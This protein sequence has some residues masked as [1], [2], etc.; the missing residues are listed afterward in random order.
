VLGVDAMLRRLAAARHRLTLPLARAARAFHDARGWV[1][2]G[3]SQLGDWSREH[4]DRSGRWLRQLAALDRAVEA[5]PQLGLALSGNDGGPPL[6]VCAVLEIAR[7]CHRPP[8]GAPEAADH[9]AAWIARARTITLAELR[10]LTRS[11]I[12]TS[13]DSRATDTH[14][15]ADL[16]ADAS[17]H[18][19]QLAVPPDVQAAFEETLDLHRAVAG[20]ETGIAGFVEALC[21][22]AST[23]ASSIST[24]ASSPRDVPVTSVRPATRRPPRDTAWEDEASASLGTTALR[25][26]DATLRRLAA[27][28][29]AL[30]S[31]SVDVGPANARAVG[32]ALADLVACQDRIEVHIG[33]LLSDLDAARPW[34]HSPWSSA[35]DP[36]AQYA[37]DRLRMSR[38]TA[39]DRVHAARCLQRLPV[40]RAAYES[41][42]L[43][44]EKTLLLLR[45]SALQPMDTPLQ[46]RWM[47][48]ATQTTLKRLR[49]EYRA[50]RQQHALRVSDPGR[51]PRDTGL[52]PLDDAAWLAS[53]GRPAGRTRSLVLETGCRI[54]ARTQAARWSPVVFLQVRLPE[55]QANDFAA[56]IDSARRALCQEAARLNA[57]DSA[58]AGDGA[59]NLAAGDLGAA[60]HHGTAAHLGAAA[61]ARLR[62]SLRIA[63]LCCQQPTGVP[64]W[65]GLL[66]LLEEYA[67]TWDAP[68]AMHR[69]R[70]DRIHARA[71]WRCTCAGC[72]RRSGLEA[73]HV[74]YRSHGGGNEPENVLSVCGLHHRLG[75]HG[76]VASCRGEAPLGIVWGLGESGMR[77]WY[78]NE[79]R[80]P[81]VH[82]P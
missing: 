16:D 4:L 80:I 39:R 9:V 29:R 44:L 67:L 18:R 41:G 47:E 78:R 24:P 12:A 7:A 70:W 76:T 32:A 75:E 68:E 25:R 49:D 50:L 34:K 5:H 23:F 1:P 17:T 77:E 59:A 61:E 28:E 81:R 6:G 43:G 60:A 21:A 71:G 45:I 10:R 79:R 11:A 35:L 65:L 40:L 53:I 15:D 2:F 72:T 36:M 66:A 82:L 58:N 20:H 38:T 56:A 73:H 42:R 27:S 14:L 74:R 19:V 3:F 52:E 13:M 37:E 57:R 33:E 30:A 63:R 54:L 64:A 8:P 46:T 55:E 31:M 62:P 48:C 26:A 69:G 51:Q 22:E